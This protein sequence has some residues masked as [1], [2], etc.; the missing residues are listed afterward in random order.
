MKDMLVL[1]RLIEEYGYNEPILLKKVKITELSQDSVRQA[2]SRLASKGLLERFSRGVYYVPTDTPFGK[3][4]L[5]PKK[6]YEKMYIRDG[7]NIFGYYTGLT[8]MNE[9]G[10]T[11]QV[12]NLVEI[13]T[14]ND[15]S[16]GRI[17]DIGYVKVRVRKSEVEVNKENVKTLQFLDLLKQVRVQDL[18]EEARDLLKN[19]VR[20]QGFKK[21]EVFSLAKGFSST[22][23]DRLI[24]SGL[25]D[26]LT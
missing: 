16:R 13:V 20:K 17:A 7:E 21:A 8:F 11:T 4:R 23:A 14:N 1:Y 12:P 25:I 6:V 2:F 10:L 19:Y 9:I 18:S 3:S 22:V 15:R 5:N 26:E 24:K